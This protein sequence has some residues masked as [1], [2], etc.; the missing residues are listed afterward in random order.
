MYASYAAPNCARRR[1]S[2]QRVTRRWNTANA[3]AAQ[4]RTLHEPYSSDSPIRISTIPTYIG[5][6]VRR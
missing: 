1:G 6:R 3:I 2:S 5:L 4:R